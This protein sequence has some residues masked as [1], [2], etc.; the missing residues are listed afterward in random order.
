MPRTFRCFPIVVDDV[1]VH[2]LRDV[3]T[4]LA[5]QP[6][7]ETSESRIS[8]VQTGTVVDP[9]GCDLVA[10]PLA[11]FEFLVESWPRPGKWFKDDCRQ[12]EV[13]WCKEN[14]KQKCPSSVR[15]EIKE[16]LS[17]AFRATVKP[18][19]ERY[20]CLVDF[21]GE[22]ILVDCG[23]SEL[24]Y[25]L[26]KSLGLRFASTPAE[27]V[28]FDLL[29]DDEEREVALI[30]SYLKWISG[31]FDSIVFPLSVVVEGASFDAESPHFVYSS[32]STEAVKKMKVF[33]R[34][35]DR[36]FSA[37]LDNELILK[38]ASFDDPKTDPYEA[39][40]LL[41]G[42]Y[43]LCMDLLRKSVLAFLE[44]P[45]GYLDSSRKRSVQ[46]LTETVSVFVKET[47]QVTLWNEAGA[48][49]IE[50]EKPVVVS[51]EEETRSR[52]VRHRQATREL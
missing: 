6:L 10:A 1:S 34:Q 30:D 27:Q 4:D 44:N 49:L 16:R 11:T 39:A 51:D 36:E 50:V 18:D 13:E 35:D 15:K 21:T 45:V 47:G 14:D 28:G 33:F 52:R 42:D 31:G 2:S 19:R 23:K 38:G 8:A 32:S 9:C 25:S 22:R 20:L 48:K 7:P 12:A 37:G 46:A 26:V 24:A 43:D 3:L 29:H 17:I 5:Y 40:F 41:M